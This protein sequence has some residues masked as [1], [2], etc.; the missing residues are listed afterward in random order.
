VFERSL[1]V[2]RP[3]GTLVAIGYAGGAWVALDPALLV[4]RNVSVAGFYLG[5]LFGL[6]PEVVSEATGDLLRLWEAGAVRP[7]IG[8]EFPLADAGAA[9]R[10]IEDRRSIGKVVLLP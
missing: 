1:K 4:G 6:A 5:R 9:H 3:L 10:L 2:L 7:V 8:A